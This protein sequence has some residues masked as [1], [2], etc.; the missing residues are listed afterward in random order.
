[1]E[2]G[3]RICTHKSPFY[4]VILSLQVPFFDTTFWM[5]LFDSA[6]I[7]DSPPTHKNFVWWMPNRERKKKEIKASKMTR[8]IP[9]FIHFFFSVGNF[10]F[11]LMGSKQ[12]LRFLDKSHAWPFYTTP[13]RVKVFFIFWRIFSFFFSLFI[14]W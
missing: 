13:C 11:S 1:M 4:R 2:R 3:R 6:R 8:T 5:C 9:I 7:S 10:F 12:H 14:H